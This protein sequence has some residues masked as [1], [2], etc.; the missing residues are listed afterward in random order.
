MSRITR[1]HS[2]RPFVV[3][4]FLALSGLAGSAATAEAQSISPERALLN[5]IPAAGYGVVAGT[6]SPF[7]ID[8]ERALLNQSIAVSGAA[9]LATRSP[10]EARAVDGEQALL[11]GGPSAQRRRLTLAW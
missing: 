10:G 9:G 11:G 2:R 5:P 6:E 7:A 8:G 4:G 3:A 1:S